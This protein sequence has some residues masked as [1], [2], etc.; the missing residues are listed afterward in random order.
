MSNEVKEN[1]RIFDIEAEVEPLFLT[2]PHP[3]NDGIDDN[4]DDLPADDFTGN[5]DDPT[6]EAW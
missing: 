3:D 2:M 6:G 5:E 1:Q 4:G